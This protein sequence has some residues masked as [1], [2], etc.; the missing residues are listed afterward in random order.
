MRA[1]IFS[2]IHLKLI[3]L[4]FRPPKVVAPQLILAGDITTRYDPELLNKY[5][6]I[7]SPLY[8]KI[9]YVPG[10]H[11]YF[12]R[13]GRGR[14]PCNEYFSRTYDPPYIT[15]E[16][17]KVCQNYP[18]IEFLYNRTLIEDN[19][20]IFGTPF[21]T[22]HLRR[23]HE[24]AKEALAS[25][26]TLPY[27]K[28]IIITHYAPLLTDVYHEKW[29]HGPSLPRFCF[30]GLS[31]IHPRPARDITWIFGHTHYA[32]DFMRNGIRFVSNPVYNEN[33]GLPFDETKIV[34]A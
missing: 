10:N 32:C 33:R 8:Q 27:R 20:A 1:Q 15:K 3:P 30:D 2:D 13:G 5:F 14:S 17:E 16:L 24:L 11:E 29:K 25:F 4:A 26:L 18:N 9:Y 6:S 31:L 19:V 28:C 23:E 21:P 12:D 7:I 34:E 22:N